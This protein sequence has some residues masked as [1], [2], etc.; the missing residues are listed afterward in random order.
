MRLVTYYEKIESNH[1]NYFNTM[2]KYCS[3]ISESLKNLGLEG[4]FFEKNLNYII[5]II[6]SEKQLDNIVLN[7]GL[8]FFKALRQEVDPSCY[9]ILEKIDAII[10]YCLDYPLFLETM[11]DIVGHL[12]ALADVFNYYRDGGGLP[13]GLVIDQLPFCKEYFDAIKVAEEEISLIKKNKENCFNAIVFIFKKYG[14]TISPQLFDYNIDFLTNKKKSLSEDFLKLEKIVKEENLLFTK[15]WSFLKNFV[16]DTK[17][18]NSSYFKEFILFLK[19]EFSDFAFSH[20]INDKLFSNITIFENN[21]IENSYKLQN[22]LQLLQDKKFFLSCNFSKKNDF[23]FFLHIYQELIFFENNLLKL[24]LKRSNLFKMFIK[25]CK[26]DF[27]LFN[28]MDSLQENYFITNNFLNLDFLISSIDKKKLFIKA[29]FF[30]NDLFLINSEIFKIERLIIS[31]KSFLNFFFDYLQ[32]KNNFFFLKA[33]ADI[34]NVHPKKKDDDLDPESFFMKKDSAYLNN[35]FL[36]FNEKLTPLFGLQNN[37][38]RKK[39][40]LI[41]K[42]SEIDFL[43]KRFNNKEKIM[44]DSLNSIKLKLEFLD[45]QK[46]QN[47]A[48]IK[49]FFTSDFLGKM[50]TVLVNQSDNTINLNTPE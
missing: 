2:V 36:I 4:I 46:M 48:Q 12:Y 25:I 21:L 3:D 40:I 10:E 26:E 33:A 17:G 39:S 23:N 34:E 42:K 29:D 20:F 38:N 22:D 7:L 11:Y 19:N 28:F 9:L 15:F 47:L 1:S 8:E 31:L 30:K 35:Q 37:L 49:G 50:G 16:G 41:D 27:Y 45:K 5:Q 44:L 43:L 32:K 13:P 14:L 6:F 18:L 24:Q